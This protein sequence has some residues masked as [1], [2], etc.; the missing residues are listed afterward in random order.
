MNRRIAS[1][2]EVRVGYQFRG[3]VVPDPGGNVRVIQIKDIDA[4]RRVRLDDLVRVQLDRPDSY[5][6]QAGDILFLARGHRQYAVVLADPIEDAVATGYFYILR[7]KSSK[8]LPEYLAWCINQDEFQD[9]MRPFAQG[10]HMPLVSRADFQELAVPIPSLETQGRIVRLDE[11]LAEERRLMAEIQAR[12]AAL[13]HAASHRA[14][15]K[16]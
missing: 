7:P 9:A 14:A 11:L 6:T 12:R 2:V 1:L 4:N 3:K 5:R 16:G 13:V 8:V 10:T 15:C